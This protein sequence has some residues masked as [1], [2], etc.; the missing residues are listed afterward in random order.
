MN[1]S[2]EDRRAN[3]RLRTR[4]DLLL[5]A[6]RLLEEGRTPGMDEIAAAAMVSR[7]PAYRYF[8]T[9]EALLLEALLLEAPLQGETPEPQTLFAG[10][11]PGDAEERIDR[12]EAALH[13]MSYANARQLRLMLAHSLARE[14][15]D[16]M[17]RRQ[18]RRTPL[19]EAALGPVRD[20]LDPAAWRRLCR[21]LALVFGTESMI[22]CTDILQI[23]E[24][25]ARELK[26]WTV[27][28]LVRAAL[29]ETKPAGARKKSP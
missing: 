28:A 20:E 27:R 9:L 1:R 11:N 6:G 4:K 14:P 22:V 12:A 2:P 7:V 18:N 16:V 8:P 26:S 21:A 17:P 10:D 3:Q 19:I 15:A 13:R 24:E 25:A 29:R 5:A 23:D